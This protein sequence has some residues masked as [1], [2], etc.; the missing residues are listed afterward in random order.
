MADCA[1]FTGG[2]DEKGIG[3]GTGFNLNIQLPRKLTGDA[4]Y[5]VALEGAIEQI[6]LYDP[7][8]LIVRQVVFRLLTLSNNKHVIYD[9]YY[10][11]GTITQTGA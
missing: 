4:E 5:L 9:Y 8:C 2:S 1:G 11:F 6:R 7:M 3:E 10:Y